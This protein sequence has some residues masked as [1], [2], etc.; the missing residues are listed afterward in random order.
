MIGGSVDAKDVALAALQVMSTED[1]AEFAR[2]IHPEATNREAADEPSECR[3]T[4]PEAFLATA[5][6]LHSAFAD[7]RWEVHDAVADGDLVVL[8]ATM[9]GRQ[10][11][12]FVGYDADARPKVVFPQTGR[13][14]AVTQTHWF[15]LR[16]G[17]VVE[18]WANRDDRGMGEQLG[19][20]PP[21]PLYL[22]RVLRATRRARAASS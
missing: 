9:S 13:P 4:G 5:R 7:L 21:S 2:L 22:V 11:G 17:Q 14:F 3:A 6:W 16:D 8:H 1:R 15:R 10:T 19:W 20:T 18:H 12:P